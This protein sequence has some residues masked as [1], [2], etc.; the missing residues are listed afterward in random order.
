VV[1]NYISN[2]HAKVFADKW[3]SSLWFASLKLLA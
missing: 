1:L 2:H 3:K